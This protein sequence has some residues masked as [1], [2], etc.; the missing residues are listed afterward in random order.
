MHGTRAGEVHTL[1]WRG[2][3]KTY[4]LTMPVSAAPGA[5]LLGCK[6]RSILDLPL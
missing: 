3:N 4:L 6:V 1:A 2:R 5:F